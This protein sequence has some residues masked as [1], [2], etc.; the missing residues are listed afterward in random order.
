M[1]IISPTWKIFK[2]IFWFLKEDQKYKN[3]QKNMKI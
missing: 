1:N 3:L 2:K